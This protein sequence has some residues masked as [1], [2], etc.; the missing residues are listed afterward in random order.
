MDVTPTT[1]TATAAANTATTAPGN[2]STPGKAL[3][4]DFETFLKMLTVQMKNQDPLNPIDSADHAMQLATFSG[5]EQQVLTNDL[6][7][8]LTSQFA[9]AGLADIAGWVGREARVNAAVS[10]DG[11]PVTVVTDRIASGATAAEM[12]VRDAQGVEVDRV[13]I[14]VTGETHEWNGRTPSGGAIA[15]GPYSFHVVSYT[16]GQT[17]QESQ[18]AVYAPVREVRIDG[19]VTSVVLAGGATVDA[20]AVT[21]LR[22]A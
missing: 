12:V 10:F 6:L 13:S 17:T 14:P 1:S 18:A 9:T 8:N 3:S 22:D 2:E 19:G 11:T 16:R 20:A 21:A 15:S 5:V 4:S 7:R